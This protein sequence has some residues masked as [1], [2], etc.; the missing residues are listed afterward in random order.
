MK[1]DRLICLW[2]VLLLVIITGCGRSVTSVLPSSAGEEFPLT[3][4]APYTE[5]SAAS[6]T[7]SG[8]AVTMTSAVGTVTAAPDVKA[9]SAERTTD[10]STAHITAETTSKATAA[11]T[12][13]PWT[14]TRQLILVCDQKNRR[15]VMLDAADTDWQDEGS[16]VWEWKPAAAN[17]FAEVAGTYWLP[18]ECKLRYSAQYHTYVIL[19]CASGG[20]CAMLEY[21]SGRKLWAT[22]KESGNNP[23]SMELLPNGN[24]AVASSGGTVRIYAAS[25]VG[26]A[27]QRYA[28]AFLDSAHGVEWDADTQRLIAT[29]YHGVKAYAVGTAEQ[30][31]LTEDTALRAD[32]EWLCGHDLIA[33]PQKPGQYWIT[34][35]GGLWV[36]DVTTRQLSEA[37][38]AL[39]GIDGD[40]NIK[41]VDTLPDGT[42]IRAMPMQGDGNRTG[43]EQ[44]QS[45]AVVFTQ[46]SAEKNGFLSTTR[47][48]PSGVAIYK[49]RSFSPV[50]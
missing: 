48:L 12:R 33:V 3:V 50:Q 1:Y 18:S 34:G 47:L 39:S 13:P 28:E 40:Y 15:L 25:Q 38:S 10:S 19:T 7:A 16:I 37:D 6:E 30:P 49:A 26:D 31:E 4:S 41:S 5:L 44:Y 14:E 23:H 42:I 21:P 24:I 32:R 17:G 43:L 35:S 9:S 36:Y 45:N 27:G 2:A 8:S 46:W 22:T 11:A 20:T 29:Y